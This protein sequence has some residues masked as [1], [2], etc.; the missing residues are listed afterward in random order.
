[1]KKIISVIALLAM[2]TMLFTAC[3]N[4]TPTDIPDGYQ[5]ASSEDCDYLFYVPE[6]WIVDS[7]TLYTSAYHS[8]GDT[9]D[10]SSLSVTAYGMNFGETT[11]ED[12]W[13]GYE[14]QFT[15]AFESYELVS[16]EDVKLDGVEG[17]QFTY[18]AK[19]AGAQYNFVCTAAVRDN[20]V[21]YMLYTSTPEYYEN[22][23]D[24]MKEAVSYFK[25]K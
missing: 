10:T 3:G 13:K 19:M 12:W 20:Y 7:R 9:G 25:F 1:M 18:T 17:K 4:D 5:L 11:V 21:Y 22:H 6:D 15:E 2:L 24:T 16:T 14:G 23:L 8:A